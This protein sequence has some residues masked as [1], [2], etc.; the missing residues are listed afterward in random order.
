M[1]IDFLPLMLVNMSAGLFLLACYGFGD[2]GRTRP[3]WAPALGITGLVATIAGFYITFKFPL[4]GPYNVAFGEMSVLLGVLFLGGSW[5][6]ARGWPLGPLAAYSLFAGAA[7]ILIGVYALHRFY[8]ES[9]MQQFTATPV[10][11]GIGFILTG[12]AGVLFG[13]IVWV[14]W[15]RWLRW[16][17]GLGLIIA[18][19]IWAVTAGLA[20]WM[21]LSRFEKW[22]PL[23]YQNIAK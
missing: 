14:S 13:P 22:M 17:V 20:Y 12:F 8:C 1:F 5:S 23:I 18:S 21:Q 2:V 7:A 4:I 9:S 6:V 10:L 15:L 16:P 19:G 11:S 3:H